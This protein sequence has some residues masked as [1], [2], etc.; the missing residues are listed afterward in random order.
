M[1]TAQAPIF[2]PGHGNVGNATDVHDF[3]NYLVFLSAITQKALESGK[4]GDDLVDAVL[5]QLT[6]TYGSWDW[7]KD[8]SH[9][10]ILDVAAE[11][12][13]TKRVPTPDKK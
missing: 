2:V 3:Q 11:L 9:S 12:K 8:F 1:K 5:P 4:T 7:F 13:G 10:D 6:Q